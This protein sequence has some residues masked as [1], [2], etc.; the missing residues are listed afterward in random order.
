MKYYTTTTEYNCGI[1]LHARQMYVCLM[2]RRGNKLIHTNVQGNDFNYFLKR[3]EPYRHS[4]TV[5][6]ECTFNWYWL[7][8]ACQRQGLTFVLAHAL[9]LKA[10]HGGKNK[11][12]RI[13]SEKLAHLLG[14]SFVSLRE[15]IENPT[16]VSGHLLE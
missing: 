8:D 5:C 9:Y 12:D 4:L 11:N 13:D 7:A 2:D 1:D 14:H 16:V 3:V 10:I 6:C 15:P